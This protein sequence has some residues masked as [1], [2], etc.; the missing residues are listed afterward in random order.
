MLGSVGIKVETQY[1]IWQGCIS[2]PYGPW[3]DWAFPILISQTT[4][5]IALFFYAS[6]LAWLQTELGTTSS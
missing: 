6:Y 5:S 2:I 3:S 4:Q 1:R